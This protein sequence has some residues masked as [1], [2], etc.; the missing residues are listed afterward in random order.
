VEVE[1]RRV[2]LAGLLADRVRLEEEGAGHGEQSSSG[3]LE[4]EGECG[5]FG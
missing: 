5:C 1:R 3:S 4:G 2:A